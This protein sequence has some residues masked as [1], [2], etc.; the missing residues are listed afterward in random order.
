MDSGLYSLDE[1][2]SLQVSSDDA[3][4]SANVC[5]N[6]V[7]GATQQCDDGNTITE[8]CAYGLSACTVCSSSCQEVAGAVSFCGDGI[9]DGFN[10]EECDTGKNPS[11]SCPYGD[12]SCSVCSNTC[13]MVAGKPSFCGDG[14]I[15]DALEQ[16]DDG[17]AFTE[18]CPYGASSCSVCNSSCQITK[19]SVSFCGDGIVDGF[20]NEQC[21]GGANPSLSCPYGETSCSV[22]NSKCEIVAGDTSFCGDT[23]IDAAEQC[24][25]GN[26]ITESCSYNRPCNVCT[27]SCR[28]IA[29]QYSF[30]GDGVVDTQHEDCDDQNSDDQDGCKACE[31]AAQAMGEVGRVVISSTSTTVYL[32]RSYQ[33]PVV[34]LSPLSY[35]EHDVA[36]ARILHVGNDSFEVAVQ[37]AQQ[38]NGDH[39]NETL[40]YMVL[41]QGIWQIEKDGPTLQVATLQT[42]RIAQST[43]KKGTAVQTPV[44]SL[45]DQRPCVFTQ[46]QTT[47]DMQFVGTR[48]K[49]TSDFVFEATMHHQEQSRDEHAVETIGW[50][51]FDNSSGTWGNLNYQVQTQSAFN[52]NWKSLSLN[53]PFS[54]TSALFASLASLN[55]A[56]PAFLRYQLYPGDVQIKLQE[57]T[58]HGSEVNHVHENISTLVFADTGV[59]L[60]W[61]VHA[62]P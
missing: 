49:H 33:N 31:F 56:D 7:I 4:A 36:V 42:N 6:G 28:E 54:A 24:D 55:G 58:S 32:Q 14:V 40:F 3:T 8:S 44:D 10:G 20:N 27:S 47:N 38:H 51:A 19:G 48:H 21:D 34:F 46:I 18:E 39:G 45:F 59:L 57:D 41:E 16:C 11:G 22:C 26:A 17:N 5:G 35:N 2:G 29:G 25:D 23:V 1:P 52:H 53:N 62:N 60:A 61:P 12:T 43:A 9:T 30:C 15:D 50:V 13:Q 37:E